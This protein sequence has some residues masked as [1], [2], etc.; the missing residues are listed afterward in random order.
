M[1][2]G[3]TISVVMA[4]YNGEKFIIQQLESIRCQLLK[5]DEVIIVDDC[6]NDMTKEI[7]TQFI[8]QHKLNHWRLINNSSNLGW[9]KNFYVASREAKGDI[10]FFSDQDDVWHKDK[11][12]EMA[13]C[14]V[15]KS[16]EALVC[17]R[18][19]IDQNG[20]LLLNR[21]EK[22]SFSNELKKTKCTESFYI[23]KTLGCCECVSRRV[24]DIYI[25]LQCPECGHDSQC[26]RIA[27]LLDGLWRMD[28][29]LIEYRVHSSNSSGISAKG[30]YGKSS[31]DSRISELETISLW[32]DKLSAKGFI[33]DIDTEICKQALE[34]VKVRLNYL[35]GEKEAS[36]FQ[37]FKY[38]RYYENT[39]M[40]IGDFA[41]KHRLNEVF[42]FFRWKLRKLFM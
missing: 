2:E 5:P 4:T 11:V 36:L 26:G 37:L 14:F 10:I 6:S 19:I 39:T 18:R 28:K 40:L 27:L 38:K 25:K 23:K 12:G 32:L 33:D 20:R 35:K 17:E 3:K 24:L 31:I 7:I 8:K 16:M 42:G 1:I 29:P 30:S 9:K 21:T 22:R 13:R 41:Y 34:G 15:D